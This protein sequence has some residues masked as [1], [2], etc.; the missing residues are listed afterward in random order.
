MYIKKAIRYIDAQFGFHEVQLKQNY[1]IITYMCD[2]A[3]VN[4]IVKWYHYLIEK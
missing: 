3:N 1:K 4:P 2:E